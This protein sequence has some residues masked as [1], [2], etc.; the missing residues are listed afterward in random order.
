[1]MLREFEFTVIKTESPGQNKVS[2]DACNHGVVYGGV[3]RT[4]T[5]SVATHPIES[6]VVR[7]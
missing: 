4:D 7:I 5:V 6:V 2:G 3:T 1:M